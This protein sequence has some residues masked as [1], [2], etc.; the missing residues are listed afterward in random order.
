MM[1]D[2]RL[3]AQVEQNIE[4]PHDQMKHRKTLIIRLSYFEKV[5]ST[6]LIQE[7]NLQNMMI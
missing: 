2:S 1:L 5:T 4:D 7:Q 6:S 3:N